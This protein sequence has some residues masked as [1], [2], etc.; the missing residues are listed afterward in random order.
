MSRTLLASIVIL[1]T[2]S[3]SDRPGTGSPTSPSAAVPVGRSAPVQ[4]TVRAPDGTPLAGALV[5]T[6][7][8]GYFPSVVTDESG[9]FWFP[10]AEVTGR[11]PLAQVRVYCPGFFGTYRDVPFRTGEAPPAALMDISLKH[12]D[13]LIEDRPLE[14]V[15]TNADPDYGNESDI[16]FGLPGARGP[17]KVLALQPRTFGAVELRAEWM[18]QDR[19]EMWVEKTYMEVSM[20][21]TSSPRQTN[22]LTLTIPGMWAV[23]AMNPAVVTVGLPRS[24]RATGGLSGPVPVRL[25]VTP[26]P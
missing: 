23:D 8:Y 4:G 24:A 2:V 16:A 11:I 10:S 12:R 13:A 1:A 6:F 5:S 26:L 20:Q 7:G 3:C 25:S 17:V 15:L 18:G 22:V 19:L 21:A 9:R 14:T